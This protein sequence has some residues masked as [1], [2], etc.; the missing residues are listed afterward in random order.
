MYYLLEKGGVAPLTAR[1]ELEE[2]L[3]SFRFLPCLHNF[4]PISTQVLTNFYADFNIILHNFSPIS[5]LTSTH[6][7][8]NVFSFH[9]FLHN[10]SHFSTQLLHISMQPSTQFLCIP[11][12]F[13][14]DNQIEMFT[15]IQIKFLELILIRSTQS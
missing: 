7:S 15:Y 13:H 6:F 1:H 12:Q 9:T 3:T 14:T 2:R 10:F 8:H 4:S 5:V 11:N